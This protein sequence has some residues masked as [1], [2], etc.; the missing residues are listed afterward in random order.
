MIEKLKRIHYM[1]YASLVFM[2]FPFISILLGEVPL[3]ALLF[4]PL[5][6]CFLSR[7]LDY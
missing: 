6:Y 2:G 4:S 1:F 3:L 7:S 5:V